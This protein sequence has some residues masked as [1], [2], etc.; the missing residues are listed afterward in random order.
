MALLD[1]IPQEEKDKGIVICGDLVDRGPRSMQ[2]VQW[3]IDNK[4]PVVTGNHELMMNDEINQA[5]NLYKNSGV[6]W[7]QGL[8]GTQGGYE[9]LCSYL[10]ETTVDG[11]TKEILNVEKV[12]EHC[13]WFKTLPFYIE[14]PDIKNEDGRYLVISHSN[15]GN[16]WKVRDSKDKSRIYHFENEIV[17]GRPRKIKDVPTIF[18]VIGHTP[19]EGGPRIRKTYANIDTG[20]FYKQPGFGVLTA[21]QFPEMVVYQQDNVDYEQPKSV[22]EEE[23]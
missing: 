3:C 5:L 4:I 18:N 8:W 7:R 16:V 15:I 11:E 9:T 23:E 12:K 2:I 21:L 1:K 20:C 6:V 13:E 17:W 14:F 10:E 19:Q 22:F